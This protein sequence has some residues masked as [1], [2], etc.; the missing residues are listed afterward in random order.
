MVWTNL[1]ADD[2]VAK[3]DPNT[4][5]YTIY[6]LPSVGT[7]LRHIAVDDAG[8]PD[9]WV[10]YREASRAAR[11]QFRTESQL[12]AARAASAVP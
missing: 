1:S 8:G 4:G 6:K 5:K 10:V 9:V 12:Q 7:E 11:I 2:A 3:L